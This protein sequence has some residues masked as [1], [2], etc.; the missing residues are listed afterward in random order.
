MT[1][2]LFST[3]LLS[4]TLLTTQASATQFVA[5]DASSATQICVAVATNKTHVLRKTQRA[6]GINK[7]LIVQKLA[8][9]NLAMTD[10]VSLYHL[11]KVADYLDIN[12]STHIA[13]KDLAKIQKT[14]NFKPTAPK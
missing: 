12:T 11:K 7:D 5:T 3:I 10:F 2:S 8:C 6:L 14:S 13:I 4:T 9:N 1:A